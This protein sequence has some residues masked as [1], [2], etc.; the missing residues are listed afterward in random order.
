MLNN[1]TSPGE[2]NISAEP[3]K[4]RTYKLWEE[5]HAKIRVMWASEKMAGN[6]RTVII[7]HEDK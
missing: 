7:W 3:T 1:N 2:D 5:I 6:W 4:C